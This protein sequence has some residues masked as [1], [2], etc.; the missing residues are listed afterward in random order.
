MWLTAAA[1][2]RNVGNVLEEAPRLRTSRAAPA[3]ES[4]NS[5]QCMVLEGHGRAGNRLMRSSLADGRLSHPDDRTN[6]QGVLIPP[7]P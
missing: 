1:R 3:S 4:L 6:A 5:G 7:E 2:P